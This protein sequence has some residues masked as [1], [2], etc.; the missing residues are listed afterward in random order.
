VIRTEDDVCIVEQ[1]LLFERAHHAFNEVIHALKGS[2]AVDERSVRHVR[3]VVFPHGW[4]LPHHPMLVRR[5]SLVPAGHARCGHVRELV[6]VL[7]GA[8]VGHVWCR[9]RCHGQERGPR[10]SSS[11][12]LL[13]ECNRLVMNEVGVVVSGVIAAVRDPLA[14]VAYV[15]V[16][17]LGVPD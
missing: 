12:V 7:G 11:G 13:D 6:A 15:I 8:D 10:P 16:V 17:V 1:P 14:V 2:P 5:G 9:S 3:G 4:N